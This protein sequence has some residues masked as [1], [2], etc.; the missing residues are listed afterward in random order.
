MHVWSFLR[1]QR[2]AADVDHADIRGQTALMYAARGGTHRFAND[3]PRPNVNAYINAVRLLVSNGAILDM[4]KTDIGSNN[5]IDLA[6]HCPSDTRYLEPW[7]VSQLNEIEQMNMLLA[8]C[9]LF[10]QY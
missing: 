10:Q 3:S 2:P 4:N 1:L 7:E 5:L 8:I 6:K 9:E